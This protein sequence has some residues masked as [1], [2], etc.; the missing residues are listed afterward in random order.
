MTLYTLMG[1]EWALPVADLRAQV[2]AFAAARD[3]GASIDLPDLAPQMAMSPAA[4]AA[5][6]PQTSTKFLPKTRS[7]DDGDDDSVTELTGIKTQT[8]DRNAAPESRQ[9]FQTPAAPSS[10]P[11]DPR[12]PL[13]RRLLRLIQEPFQSTQI[14]TVPCAPETPSPDQ[15]TTRSSL[16]C[17]FQRCHS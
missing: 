14:P 4:D 6:S 11:A 12:P 10:A 16:C 17:F 15:A 7:F 13:S 3:E 5:P 9:A 8:I 1:A 2:A